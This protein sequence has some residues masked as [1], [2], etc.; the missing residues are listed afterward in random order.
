MGF[1]LHPNNV[2]QLVKSL[3]M[4]CSVDVLVMLEKVLGT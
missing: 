2:L 3:Y 4:V 1:S